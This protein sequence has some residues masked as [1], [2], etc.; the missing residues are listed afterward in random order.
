MTEKNRGWPALPLDAWEPTRATLHM[1][2]QIVGK[3]RL[4]LS[5]YMNHW[6]QV[7][8]YVTARGLTTSP[9]PYDGETF[10]IVGDGRR[11][12]AAR[13]HIKRHLPPM[14][15]VRAKR[16]PYFADDLRPH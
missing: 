2:T 12:K 8:L 4:A 13:S 6:W 16:Q 9:I 7:P 5:P 1:W 10:E 3:V 11:R 14:V 15:H